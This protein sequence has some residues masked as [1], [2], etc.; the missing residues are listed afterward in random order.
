MEDRTAHDTARAERALRADIERPVLSK[1]PVAFRVRDP[2]GK[3]V[4]WDDENACARY[5]DSIGA[6]YQGLYA[7]D[8]S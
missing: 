8:G 7:R 3:W 2:Q 5:A 1:R 6:D 4:L